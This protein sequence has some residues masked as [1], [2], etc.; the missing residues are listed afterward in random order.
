MVFKWYS[1]RGPSPGVEAIGVPL[2]GSML[3]DS[4]FR[5]DAAGFHWSQLLSVALPQCVPVC[6]RQGDVLDVAHQ[7]VYLLLGLS[8]V[9]Q[10]ASPPGDVPWCRPCDYVP[11]VAHQSVFLFPGLACVFQSVGPPGDVPWCGPSD[12]VPVVAPFDRFFSL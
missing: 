12:Y 8:C 3:P 5:V 10:S 9:I 4:L 7:S 1:C 11:V 2:W 6:G